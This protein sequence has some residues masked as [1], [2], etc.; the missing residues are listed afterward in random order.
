ME[1]RRE[2]KVWVLERTRH[3]HDPEKAPLL[4]TAPLMPARRPEADSRPALP[5]NI[6]GRRTSPRTLRR[7]LLAYLLGPFAAGRWHRFWTP[8]SASGL[9]VIGGLLAFGLLDGG[10]LAGGRLLQRVLFAVAAAAS[11][12]VVAGWCFSLMRT[13]ESLSSPRQGVPTP[14][15]RPGIAAFAGLWLPGFALLLAGSPRRAALALG[16][17]GVLM[18][19]LLIL[20]GA[21]EVVPTGVW[22]GYE[23]ML[24]AALGTAFAAGLLW[25]AWALEG[26]RLQLARARMSGGVRGDR[27]A[28]LLLAAVAV[29]AI[30]FQPATL[31]E[32]LHGKAESL[33][34]RGYRLLPLELE[35]AALRMDDSRPAYWLRAAEYCESLGRD[36][37]GA[38][39]RGALWLRWREYRDSVS[40]FAPEVRP[41]TLAGSPAAGPPPSTL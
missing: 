14:L 26:L 29:F 23:R 39:Y 13:G 7:I 32:I 18:A 37:D 36:Q 31:S 22:I 34:A 25:S 9:A 21:E 16:N 2:D 1:I 20:R 27:L 11:G 10:A 17:F 38:R 41:A 33:A 12:I 28:L 6:G 8:A 35:R 40:G 15:R 19:A 5:R 30:S 4:E 24:A 3:L